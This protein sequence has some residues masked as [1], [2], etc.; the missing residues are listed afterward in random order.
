MSCCEDTNPLDF[1][2][3]SNNDITVLSTV[4]NTYTNER[5][6]LTGSYIKLQVFDPLTGSAVITKDTTLIGGLTILA[7]TGDTLGQFMTD[8]L[9][10]DTKN[11]KAGTYPYEYV[12]V[13]ADGRADNLTNN[14]PLLS[15]GNIILVKQ[16]TEQP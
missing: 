10:D 13:A 5:Q 1:A 12:V 16:L 6:D 9:A 4:I 8:Y 11:L 15:N 3:K 2:M 7:Q 14:D